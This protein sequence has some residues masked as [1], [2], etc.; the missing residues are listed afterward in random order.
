M[1]FI[2][3]T[4]SIRKIEKNGKIMAII[5]KPLDLSEA[6]NFLTPEEFPFQVGV[7]NRKA[8]SKIE[9][10]VHVPI[11]KLENLEIQELF[12]VLIGSMEVSLFDEKRELFETV[13]LKKNELILVNCGHGVKFSEDCKFFEIKQGPYRGKSGEKI[14][15]GE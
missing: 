9:S 4:N 14:V 12:F 10:H 13:T 15:I 3:M 5:A 8:G 1:F 7:H 11:D 6:L 2:T